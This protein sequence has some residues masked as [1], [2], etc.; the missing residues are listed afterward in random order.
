MFILTLSVLYVL[1]FGKNIIK[2]DF[3]YL[4][5]VCW[6]GTK[7]LLVRSLLST[8]ESSGDPSDAVGRLPRSPTTSD[9]GEAIDRKMPMP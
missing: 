5:K 7:L 9:L 2:F 1:P 3:L 6:Y 8:H 4:E